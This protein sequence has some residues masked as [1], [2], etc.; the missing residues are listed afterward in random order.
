MMA[1]SQLMSLQISFWAIQV[2]LLSPGCLNAQCS[3]SLATRPL[4]IIVVGC[5]VSGIMMTYKIQKACQN[6]ELCV[7]ERNTDLGGTWY[8]N[9]YPGAGCD[10]PAHTYTYNFAL[11]PDWPRYCAYRDDIQEYCKYAVFLYRK[12]RLR[13]SRI[14]NKVARVFGL[15]K[16]MQFNSEVL[17]ATWNETSA[18]WTIKVRQ[19]PGKNEGNCHVFERTCDVFLYATG[20]FAQFKM[21]KLRGS[22]IFKGKVSN[23]R[24]IR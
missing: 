5:G 10:I 9:R 6:V 7:Y 8:E 12:R 2:N 24:E 3:R 4:K 21:P 16:Y 15:R 23:S 1:L 20:T 19:D 14:V 11:Y 13:A 18:Q 17:S 22:D